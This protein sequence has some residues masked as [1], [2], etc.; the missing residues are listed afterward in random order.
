MPIAH[1]PAEHETQED[2]GALIYYLYA[3]TQMQMQLCDDM[4]SRAGAGA[5]GGN[6]LQQRLRA[7]QLHSWQCHQYFFGSLAE[8]EGAGCQHC[9]IALRRRADSPLYRCG[10]RCQ[11][12]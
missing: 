9:G 1:A 3:K 10:H 11:R 4:F 5:P 8:G 7:L 2:P 12:R 6:P